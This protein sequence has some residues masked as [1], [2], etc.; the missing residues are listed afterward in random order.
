M[1]P[2]YTE[3][4]NLP[5]LPDVIYVCDRCKS[6]LVQPLFDGNEWGNHCYRCGND[7]PG[8]KY[9]RAD[10][11]VNPTREERLQCGSY[12]TIEQSCEIVCIECGRD[13][14]DP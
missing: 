12:E 10:Q 14:T 1:R 9:V 5:P 6:M 11:A 3:Y 8:L 4:K 7:E 2:M 13:C